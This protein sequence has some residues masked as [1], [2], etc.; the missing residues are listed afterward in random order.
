[1]VEVGSRLFRSGDSRLLAF[2]LQAASG[3]LPTGVLLARWLEQAGVGSRSVGFVRKCRLCSLNADATVGHVL[4]VCPASAPLRR[5]LLGGARG[6]REMTDYLPWL[7]SRAQDL[8]VVHGPGMPL[9]EVL[10]KEASGLQRLHLRVD[11]D[12]LAVLAERVEDAGVP[13]DLLDPQQV[14]TGVACEMGLPCPCLNASPPAWTENVLWT[15]YSHLGIDSVVA[16]RL[17]VPRRPATWFGLGAEDYE[18]G[19]RILPGV[20]V[21][22]NETPDMSGLRTLVIIRHSTS[23]QFLLHACARAVQSVSPTRIVV[24][25]RDTHTARSLLSHECREA[26]VSVLVLSSGLRAGFDLL[27]E[28]E[29]K[30]EDHPTLGTPTQGSLP[31]LVVLLQ[32]EAAYHLWPYDPIAIQVVISAVSVWASDCPVARGPGPGFVIREPQASASLGLTLQKGIWSPRSVLAPRSTPLEMYRLPWRSAN[33]QYGRW[34]VSDL[35]SFWLDPTGPGPS[36]AVWRGAGEQLHRRPGCMVSSWTYMDQARRFHE[37]GLALLGLVPEPVVQVTEQDEDHG[38]V[39]AVTLSSLGLSIGASVWTLHSRLS[40]AQQRYVKDACPP[41]MVFQVKAAGIWSVSGGI[42]DLGRP[43]ESILD[44]FRSV[45]GRGRSGAERGWMAAAVAH[46]DEPV[47][48]LMPLH[49][50]ELDDP[51][52]DAYVPGDGDL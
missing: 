25:I 3:C 20:R 37:S 36:S 33:P 39:G 11:P 4:S 10:S 7:A 13:S 23:E 31:M 15:L 29:G 41:G 51:E 17:V 14:V 6:F 21:G 2:L 40:S 27:Q 49:E 47:P 42:R 26:G 32:N 43:Q 16:S 12:Q 24:A 38:D 9:R 19:A 45:S 44:Y 52:A 48:L 30:D 28:V 5:R 34:T 22:G 35:A 18:L 46:V 1:M 50:H 8:V